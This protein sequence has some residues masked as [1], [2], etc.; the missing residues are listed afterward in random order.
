MEESELDRSTHRQT[1]R[2]VPDHY[3]DRLRCSGTVTL[4]EAYGGTV[5]VAEADLDVRFPFV[6]QTVARTIVAG[7]VDNA[8]TQQR[9][10]A[11]WL[12]TRAHPA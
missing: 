7:L 10:V 12:S 1:F 6:G 8:A 5:R 4:E 11:V 2:I 9:A 3:G